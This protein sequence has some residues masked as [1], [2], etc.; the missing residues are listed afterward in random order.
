MYADYHYESARALVNA[1]DELS[2]GDY[3]QKVSRLT[4]LSMKRAVNGNLLERRQPNSGASPPSSG[5]GARD[6]SNREPR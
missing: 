2:A 1:D 4:E 6:R 5:R 3:A